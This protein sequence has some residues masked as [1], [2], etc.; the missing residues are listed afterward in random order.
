MSEFVFSRA[1]DQRV[2]GRLPL[3]DLFL[4]KTTAEVA[5]LLLLA[6]LHSRPSCPRPRLGRPLQLVQG[7]EAAACGAR[8]DLSQPCGCCPVLS[9]TSEFGRRLLRSIGHRRKNLLLLRVP[10]HI[11]RG[12]RHPRCHSGPQ[13][14][15]RGRE[16][17]T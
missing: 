15:R 12:R 13:S 7:G 8:G 3:V 6:A 10:Q 16:S 14:R 5:R 1:P 2:H 11:E 17:E 4:R 9:F